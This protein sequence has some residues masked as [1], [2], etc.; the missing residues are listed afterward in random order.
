MGL[1]DAYI[2]EISAGAGFGWLLI[3]AG[4]APNDL[5]SSAAQLQT[6]A[7]S[8]SDA[9]VRPPIGETWIIKRLLDTGAQSL[10]I[11]MVETAT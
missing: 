8:D 3:D 10:L 4:H 1:A 9:V 6:L 11:P 7:A 2:A 5:R